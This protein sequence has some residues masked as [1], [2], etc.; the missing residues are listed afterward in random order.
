MGSSPH[1]GFRPGR[2]QLPGPKKIHAGG[3]TSQV[4]KAMA[5]NHPDQKTFAG[6]HP[7]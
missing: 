5:H 3:S 2:Q 7:A 6:S 1:F 4:K